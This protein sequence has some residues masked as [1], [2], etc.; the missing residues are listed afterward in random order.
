VALRVLYLTTALSVNGRDAFRGRRLF[1]RLRGVSE[2]AVVGHVVWG[3]EFDDAPVPSEFMN[4]VVRRSVLDELRPNV[5]YLEGGLCPMPSGEWRFPRLLLE[6]LVRDGAVAIVA[7]AD[8]R[9][10]AA[11]KAAYRDAATFLGAHADYGADDGPDPVYGADLTSYWRSPRTVVVA[12]EGMGISAW[13]KPVYEHVDEIVVD[14]PVRLSSW[15]ELLATCNLDSSGTLRHDLWV[16]EHDPVPFASVRPLGDGFM[17]LIAGGVS[18][19]HLLER[20]P[21]NTDWLVR[22]AQF[23]VDEAEKDTSRRSA[24]RRLQDVVEA[25]RAR[26]RVLADEDAAGD[27]FAAELEP[28]LRDLKRQFAAEQLQQARDRME[29]HFGADWPRLGE[30]ARTFLITGEVL[31]HHLE[32]YVS[33]EPAWDFSS[34]VAAYSQALESSLLERVFEPYR[35]YPGAIA[36][37]DTLDDERTRQSAEALRKF[38]E[39]GKLTLGQMAF[40]LLNLGCAQ[41][42]VEDNAFG[43]YLAGRLVDLGRFCDGEKWPTRLRRYND[44]FRNRAAHVDRLTLQDCI[45]AR[46]YLLEEPTRLLISLG[47]ALRPD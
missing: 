5:I 39:G 13:L 33:V 10:L 25:A 28:A 34:A 41:R 7:D 36:L 16:N 1:D 46:A 42:D 32:E 44:K 3:P 31:R 14:S 21:G 45:E 40:C 22:V 30:D 6:S 18:S 11:E 27:S 35:A 43:R 9:V 15:S 38:V 29:R 12:P 8:Q 37:P 47:R 17:V 2:E 19:D 26:V 23:L 4:D 24:L 20:C